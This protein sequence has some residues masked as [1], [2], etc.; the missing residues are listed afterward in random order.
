[1][2]N[3]NSI[4]NTGGKEC[5][6]EMIFVE[7]TQGATFLF[8]EET[9][10]KAIS[11]KDFYISKYPVTQS[12]W[13]CITGN[14]NN[15]HRRDNNKPVRQVSWNDITGKDGFLEKINSVNTANKN[16]VFRL[17]SETEW[18]YAARG[19]KNWPDD[20]LYSGSNDIDKVAWYQQN[21]NDEVKDAGLKAPNQLGIYEMN[22]N[23]WEWCG[24][25]YDPDTN[26]IPRD[27]SP[28]NGEGSERVLRGGLPS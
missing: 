6:L 22:G 23:I 20:F 21:S 2:N 28:L 18:E 11:I 10:K 26:K 3:I 17:P 12:L 13:N 15:A 7:G 27:G 24:D 19:G 9:D 1:M 5:A 25:C 14:K 8:G 16:A 4:F